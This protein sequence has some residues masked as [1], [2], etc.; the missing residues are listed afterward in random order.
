MLFLPE[1]YNNQIIAQ[2]RGYQE[3][4]D[5]LFQMTAEIDSIYGQAYRELLDQAETHLRWFRAEDEKRRQMVA[6]GKLSEEDYQIWRR[7]QLMTGRNNYA[8]VQTMADTLTAHNVVAAS[9]IN[10][11]LPEVYAINGDYA[12]YEVEHHFGINTMF[13]LYDEQTVQRLIR[14]KPDLLPKAKVDIPKDQRWNKE[15]LNAAVIQSVIQ[16]DSVNK[17]AERLAAVTDMNRTSALRNAATM[18]T[19]AQNGGRMDGYRRAQKLGVKGLKHRWV[20]TLDGHTRLSHRMVDGEVREIDKTFSNGLEY[21]GDPKG[22]PEE[23]YNCRC[24]TIAAFD[25]SEFNGA[26]GRNNRIYEEDS[27]VRNMSYDQWKHAKGNEPLFKSARNA[28]RD[29]KMHEEYKDLLKNKV[30]SRFKDFQELKYGNK[31]AWRQM[32]SDARKARNERRRSNAV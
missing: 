15:K 11:Y 8:M 3:T 24:V 22:L 7:N 2:D 28:N 32:V 18:T 25:D 21:P 26:E 29:L 20:A 9:V 23:V 4:E 19:S 5:I 30:P 13:T 27:A 6:D 17:L 10:G 31:Q 16:G 14:E 1:R 12:T